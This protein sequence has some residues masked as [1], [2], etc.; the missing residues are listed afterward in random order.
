LAQGRRPFGFDFTTTSAFPAKEPEDVHMGNCLRQ[1]RQELDLD[2][3]TVAER[4]EIP[5][6]ALEEYEDGSE[7]PSGATFF[8]LMR[9]LGLKPTELFGSF[10]PD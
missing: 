7:R 6:A 1:R 10:V 8:Q 5:L 4:I 9:I 3:Q 2:I